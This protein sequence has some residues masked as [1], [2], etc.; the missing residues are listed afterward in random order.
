MIPYK[1]LKE[2]QIYFNLFFL[3]IPFQLSPYCVDDDK[4]MLHIKNKI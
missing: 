1:K 3:L 4:H 2:K